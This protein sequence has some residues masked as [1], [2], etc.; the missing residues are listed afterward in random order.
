MRLS[1]ELNQAVYF[2]EV[3]NSELKPGK[4]LCWGRG[5]AFVSTGEEELWVPTKLIKIR[6]EESRTRK[7]ITPKDGVPGEKEDESHP[8]ET[9]PDVD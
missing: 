3:L 2:K 1:V 4:V 7:E 9:M 6:H 8:T 5:Y